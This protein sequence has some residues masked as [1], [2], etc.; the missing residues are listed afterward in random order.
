[1]SFSC[2][3]TWPTD[4]WLVHWGC[5]CACVSPNAESPHYSLLPGAMCTFFSS[6]AIMALYC[7]HQFGPAIWHLMKCTGWCGDVFIC[8]LLPHLYPFSMPWSVLEAGYSQVDWHMPTGG[9]SH[10]CIYACLG[11]CS[12]VASGTEPRL[13]ESHCMELSSLDTSF[14]MSLTRLVRIQ[15]RSLSFHTALH[16]TSLTLLT[17]PVPLCPTTEWSFSFASFLP[18][19]SL[20]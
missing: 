13:T 16:L 10:T 6:Q 15:C 17:L 1:M 11:L 4:W 5:T 9:N 2:T 14:A 20:Q 12:V 18:S 7:L 19:P 8:A 3:C